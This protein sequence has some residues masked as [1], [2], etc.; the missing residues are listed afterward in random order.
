MSS[1]R[2]L[3]TSDIERLLV[4]GRELRSEYLRDCALALVSRAARAVARWTRWPW[5]ERH[6][7][8]AQTVSV[9]TKS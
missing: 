4:R 6:R 3:T 8:N 7:S 5:G 1:D 2:R 9:P